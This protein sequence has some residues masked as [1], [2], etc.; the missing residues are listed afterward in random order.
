MNFGGAEN[1]AFFWSRKRVKCAVKMH[2]A[3]RSKFATR[4]KQVR[5]RLMDWKL[6]KSFV[7]LTVSC[8]IPGNKIVRASFAR[9]FAVSSYSLSKQVF[10]HLPL[11]CKS[12]VSSGWKEK[13]AFI[14]S[15]LR[16]SKQGRQRRR[17][18]QAAE[19]A[20]RKAAV[21]EIGSAR[22][23]VLIFGVPPTLAFRFSLAE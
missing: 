3:S 16:Q 6:H 7:H 10:L 12:P 23:N 2:Q 18:R 21:G 11:I 14:F 8:S 15:S 22:R 1:C 19:A 20:G 17:R 9:G 13:N 5:S 4:A